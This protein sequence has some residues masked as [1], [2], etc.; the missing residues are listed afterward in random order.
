MAILQDALSLWSQTSTFRPGR[1]TVLRDRVCVRVSGGLHPT[2][3][4]TAWNVRHPALSVVEVIATLRMAD[5]THRTG[6]KLLPAASLRS[7]PLLLV[8]ASMFA[9]RSELSASWDGTALASA[10]KG[11]LESHHIPRRPLVPTHLQPTQPQN[12]AQ[13]QSCTRRGGSLAHD[14][15]RVRSVTIH[16][17]AA[18]QSSDT[19]L[20]HSTSYDLPLHSSALVRKRLASTW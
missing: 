13:Q 4:K 15:P 19:A 16:H 12:R 7:P 9:A 1:P 20:H 10:E 14:V 5:A 6:E 11:V 17:M 8:R 18:E 3:K 2:R